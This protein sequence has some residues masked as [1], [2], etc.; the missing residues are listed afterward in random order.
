MFVYPIWSIIPT[1]RI[2]GTN[3]DASKADETNLGTNQDESL[4]Q[5]I[6]LLMIEKMMAQ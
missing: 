3:P 1:R 6:R 5:L 4:E 2:S